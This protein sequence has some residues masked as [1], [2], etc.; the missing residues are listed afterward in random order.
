MTPIEV[1]NRAR[2]SERGSAMAI[3]TAI[4]DIALLLGAPAVGFLIDGFGYLAAFS[5]AGVILAVG[6][7][8]YGRWDSRLPSPDS[9]LVDEE[10]RE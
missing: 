10:V 8:I 3:F 9:S 1:V 4:F 5:V 7:V 2:I 6:S